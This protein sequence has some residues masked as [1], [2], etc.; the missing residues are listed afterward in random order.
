MLV[1]TS[2]PGLAILGGA[3]KAEMPVS[4]LMRWWVFAVPALLAEMPSSMAKEMI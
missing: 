1:Q 2:I 3:R 4:G